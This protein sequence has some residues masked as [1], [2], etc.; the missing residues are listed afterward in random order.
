MRLSKVEIETLERQASD[1]DNAFGA[2]TMKRV[3]DEVEA[4]QQENEQLW[5]QMA[6]VKNCTTCKYSDVYGCNHP[7]GTEKCAGTG[8]LQW[9]PT[10]YHNPADVE[11]LRKA[12]TTLYDLMYTLNFYMR[13]S[14]IVPDNMHKRHIQQGNQTLAEIDARINK[15]I[16]GKEDV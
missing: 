5:A 8:Y 16:G 9:E 15:A 1:I 7:N 12:S 6:R 2:M 13:E 10:D 3:L 14:C 4:L 11:A